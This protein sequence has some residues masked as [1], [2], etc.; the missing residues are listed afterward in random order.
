ML[1]PLKPVLQPKRLTLKIAAFGRFGRDYIIERRN[2][3]KA[4]KYYRTVAI[5][6]CFPAVICAAFISLTTH[7]EE[8]KKG[9]PEYIP[10][11]FR[12]I[13]NKANFFSPFPWG[14]GNHVLFHN[15]KYDWVPGVGYEEDF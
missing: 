1:R 15:P 10:Y 5:F 7:F 4:D 2:A 14:D 6:V 9:R 11:E 3:A 13:R 12:S 8:Q